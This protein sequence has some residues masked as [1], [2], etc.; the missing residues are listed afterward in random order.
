MRP[1]LSW[2]LLLLGSIVVD[3]AV[4]LLL[5]RLG[6][7]AVLPAGGV[8][9]LLPAGVLRAGPAFPG[10][11]WLRMLAT[12][13]GPP[14]S[15]FPNHGRAQQFINKDVFP[16][17]GETMDDYDEVL[18]PDVCLD[19][20]R[21]C[22]KKAGERALGQKAGGRS[23][24]RHQRREPPTEARAFCRESGKGGQRTR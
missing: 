21:A 7:Y 14:G 5:P 16:P 13:S 20:K 22:L 8:Q 12:T 4:S 19:K 2:A 11:Q 17:P 23:L 3:V 15:F 9:G 24:P 6:N 10:P 1:A 18:L